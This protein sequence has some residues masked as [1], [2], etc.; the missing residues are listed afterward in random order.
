MQT[1]QKVCLLS[2]VSEIFM[3]F[4]CLIFLR[5]KERGEEMESEKWLQELFNKLWERLGEEYQVTKVDKP[6]LN[7]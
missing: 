3:S 6:A 2:K 5:L 4:W 7:S 1:R